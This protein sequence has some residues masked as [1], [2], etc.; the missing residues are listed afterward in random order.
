MFYEDGELLLFGGQFFIG[1]WYRGEMN[2][3]IGVFSF[4]KYRCV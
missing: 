2:V 1:M 4:G 3:N